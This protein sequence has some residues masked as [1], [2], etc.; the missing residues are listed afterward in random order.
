MPSRIAQKARIDFNPFTIHSN[1]REKLDYYIPSCFTNLIQHNY[2]FLIVWIGDIPKWFF[3]LF[4][5]SVHRRHIRP[6]LDRE[7]IPAQIASTDAAAAPDY[8][9]VP[10]PFRLFS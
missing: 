10:A 2:Q 5:H 3:P 9:P 4:L 7:R 1:K 8:C 6:G